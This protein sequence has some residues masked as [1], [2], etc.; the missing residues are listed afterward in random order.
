MH[1]SKLNQLM[2]SLRL[3]FKDHQLEEIMMELEVA[4]SV[5]E[6]G[7]QQELTAETNHGTNGPSGGMEWV[8]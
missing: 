6:E 8:S 3:S 2:K 7:H 5:R 4:Q 1:I